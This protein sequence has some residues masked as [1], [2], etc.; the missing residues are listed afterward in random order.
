MTTPDPEPSVLQGDSKIFYNKCSFSSAHV[1][2]IKKSKQNTVLEAHQIIGSWNIGKMSTT[3]LV[4]SRVIPWILH[5]TSVSAHGNVSLGE[6]N[7]HIFR[8][9]N[10]LR[11]PLKYPLNSSP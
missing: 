9:G 7:P 4:R 6:L 11:D 2:I 1:S 3:W 5:V 8:G 10:T